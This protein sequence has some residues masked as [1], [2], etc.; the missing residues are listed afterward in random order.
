MRDLYPSLPP[1][2]YTVSRKLRLWLFSFVAAT[3]L[4]SLLVVT[5][6]FFWDVWIRH[7]VGGGPYQPRVEFVVP[8]I[9]LVAWLLSKLL[10]DAAEGRS[11]AGGPTDR[12]SSS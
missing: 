7:W 2:A 12:K 3:M 9:L 6:Q 5:I 4:V 8:S 10:W 11:K 1:K